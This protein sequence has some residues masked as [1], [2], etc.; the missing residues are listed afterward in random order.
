LICL[1]V[2]IPS[3]TAAADTKVLHRPV[4]IEGARIFYREAGRPSA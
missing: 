3:A 1:A 4:N 2:L